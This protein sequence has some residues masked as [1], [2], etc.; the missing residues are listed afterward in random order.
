MDDRLS[1]YTVSQVLSVHK[2]ILQGGSLNIQANPEEDVVEER[3]IV[4]Q[5][6]EEVNVLQSILHIKYRLHVSYEQ[7]LC[8][9]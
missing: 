9:K 7:G 3:T 2:R 6:E 5:L 1:W 8:Q 4:L